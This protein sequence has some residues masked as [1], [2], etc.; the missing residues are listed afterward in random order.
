MTNAITRLLSAARS[1]STKSSAGAP[2]GVLRTL[3]SSIVLLLHE[4]LHLVRATV[5]IGRHRLGFGRT[6]KNT[7]DELAKALAYLTES[8]LVLSLILK[9]QGRSSH[10]GLLPEFAASEELEPLIYCFLVIYIGV[11]GHWF[12]CFFSKRQIPAAATLAAYAY[13]YGFIQTLFPLAMSM[14]L[15][16]VGLSGYMK[17]VHWAHTLVATAVIVFLFWSILFLFRWLADIHGISAIKAFFGVL[18]RSVGHI[19]TACFYF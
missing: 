16:D 6:L 9:F 13:W 17:A 3:A 12:A 15:D 8:L 11:G 5:E 18:A 2:P 19:V 4:H 1:A 14:P 7:N 10:M